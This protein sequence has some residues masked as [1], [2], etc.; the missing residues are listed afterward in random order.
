MS[1]DESSSPSPLH[2]TL[3]SRNLERNHTQPSME[4]ISFSSDD[5]SS[6]QTSTVFTQSTTSPSNDSTLRGGKINGRF[7]Y[8]ARNAST[9]DRHRIS[10]FYDALRARAPVGTSIY[11]CH[12][13]HKLGESHYHVVFRFPKKVHWPNGRGKFYIEGDTTSIRIE[14]PRCRQPV[15]GYLENV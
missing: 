10:E 8:I 5:E 2:F 15:N 14:N 11:G 3:H 7:T 9:F 12:E 4:F 1:S 13:L 6:S